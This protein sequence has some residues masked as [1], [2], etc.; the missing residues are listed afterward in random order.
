MQV[1]LVCVAEAAQKTWFA[2]RIASGDPEVD[3]IPADAST[4]ST[5]GI[6]ACDKDPADIPGIPRRTLW[7]YISGFGQQLYS[8]P[9]GTV[10]P[11]DTGQHY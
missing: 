4:T 1:I 6:K 7:E 3:V 11:A 9:A 5:A 8:R 10:F 2:S